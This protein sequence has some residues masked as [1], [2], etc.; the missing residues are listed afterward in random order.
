MPIYL[1]YDLLVKIN[2][3]VAHSFL[4]PIVESNEHT[5]PDV[6]NNGVV[7][8]QAVHIVSFEEFKDIVF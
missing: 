4:L 7:W 8:T 2:G 1:I 5:S 6:S 3:Y